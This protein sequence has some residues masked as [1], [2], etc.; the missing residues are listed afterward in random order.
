MTTHKLNASEREIKGRKVKNLRK[1]GII[2]ANVFGKKISSYMI[3]VDL[4]EFKKVFKEAGETGIIELS[5]GK[6]TSP[7][8]ISDVQVSPL[9]SENILHIDFLQVDLKEK[10]SATVPVVIEGEAPAEKLGLGML[11][12][13]IDEV[14]VEALPADLPE[15]IVCDVSKIETLEDAIFVKD[16]KFDKSKVEI[17]TD[18]ELMVAQVQEA[19]EEVAEAEPA[20]VEETEAPTTE[21]ENKQD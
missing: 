18:V 1:E 5:V 9:D 15:N 4:G 19:K 3:S 13:L 10:V 2:P 6:K 7:V 17:Q 8:L 21:E 20:P 12:Q 11:V 14:D 16:L